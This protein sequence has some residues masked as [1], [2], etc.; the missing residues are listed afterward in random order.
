[1]KD[2][3]GFTL[4][5]AVVTAVIASLIMLVVQS[6]FSHSVRS[7]LKGEDSLDSIRAASRLFAKLQEDL[8]QLTE[9]DTFSAE[10]TIPTNGVEIPSGTLYANGLKVTTRSAIITYSVV[11]TTKGKYVER[12]EK[13]GANVK[14]M[15]FGVPRIQEFEVLLVKIKNE[16]QNIPTINGQILVNLIIGSKNKN[17]PSSVIALSALFF[18]DRLTVTDWNSINF[19]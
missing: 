5:E 11:T 1:M 2:R 4:V 18:P 10:C 6:L 9:V 14:K 19:P 12:Q 8:M 7:A 13:Q 16:V 3:K 15:K 17:F